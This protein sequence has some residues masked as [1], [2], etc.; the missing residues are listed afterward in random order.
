MSALSVLGGAKGL[1]PR[2]EPLIFETMNPKQYPR[3]S[4]RFHGLVVRTQTE[5]AEVMGVT[6][7]CVHTLETRAM[8]KLR[9]E[10]KEGV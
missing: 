5:V 4:D 10:W 1:L 2:L 9:R 3:K 7:Q 8:E 6:K